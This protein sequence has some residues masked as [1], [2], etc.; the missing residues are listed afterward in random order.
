MGQLT[1]TTVKRTKI[2]SYSIIILA[3]FTW[4]FSE[5]IVKLLQ[6][7]VGPLSLSFFRFFIGGICLFAVLIFKRDLSGIWKMIKENWKLLLI[8]SCFALGLSNVIY[9]I[10]ITYTQANIGATIYTTYPIWITIYSIFILKERG[11]LKLKFLGIVIG[12]LG[13]AI[14]LTNFNLFAL[15]SAE[16]LFGNFLVLV[17]AIIWGFYSVIGKKIQMNEPELSNSALKFSMLSMLLACL[18]I[19]TILIFTPEFDYFL[20]YDLEEWFWILFLGIISTGLGIF[21]LFE[22]IKHIETSK[23]MSLAFLKPIFATILAYFILN[24]LPTLVLLFSIFLVI[25]SILLINRRSSIEDGS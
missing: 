21:L 2:Q 9:F 25:I 1:A 5:I 17:G 8:A 24:E 6:G 22:G 15:L 13:V 20:S 3:V 14:L 16:N 4:S 23:G 19:F 12:I 11:N 10:G 7:S 18:P